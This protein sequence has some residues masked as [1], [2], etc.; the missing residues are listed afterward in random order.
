MLTDVR[1][2]LITYS[3]FGINTCRDVHRMSSLQTLHSAKPSMAAA[4]PI[5]Q[6]HG[7]R[8]ARA[9]FEI[10]ISE[11]WVE[12]RDRDAL[13]HSG[14]ATFSYMVRVGHPRDTLWTTLRSTP[15]TAMGQFFSRKLPQTASSPFPTKTYGCGRPCGRPVDAPWTLRGQAADK[16]FEDLAA[17]RFARRTTQIFSRASIK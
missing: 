17:D 5:C 6:N 10:N 12:L 9:L 4:P 8:T 2:S 11:F 14:S 1:L 7:W 3:L 13:T 15:G 16:P